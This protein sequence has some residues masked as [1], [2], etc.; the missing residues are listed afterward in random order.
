[1]TQRIGTIVGPDGQNILH[2]VCMYLSWEL[3]CNSFA[4]QDP[5]P[6]FF[7]Q[8]ILIFPRV[9]LDTTIVRS[10]CITNQYKSWHNICVAEPGVR[11]EFGVTWPT[12]ALESLHLCNQVKRCKFI[13]LTIKGDS[14]NQGLWSDPATHTLS[15]LTSGEQ[16]S[17]A[18]GW[19]STRDLHAWKTLQGDHTLFCSPNLT[20]HCQYKCGWKNRLSR[21]KDTLNTQ[22]CMVLQWAQHLW[23]PG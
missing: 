22:Q 5:L 14:R 18:S 19:G 13:S 20:Y 7:C 12:H 9:T 23:Q 11:K 3:D 6:C 1:M 2:A 21:R 4:C 8:A 17:A 15:L 16:D 10:Y